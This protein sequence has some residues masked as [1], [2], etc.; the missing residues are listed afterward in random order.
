M[1]KQ[2][3]YGVW[4]K[5]PRASGVPHTALAFSFGQY[6][7]IRNYAAYLKKLTQTYPAFQKAFTSY[8]DQACAKTMRL[9]REYAPT[10]E[11]RPHR[12]NRPGNLKRSAYYIGPETTYFDMN[13]ERQE[14]GAYAKAKAAASRVMNSSSFSMVVGFSA[15]Y[16]LAVHELH[17]DSPQFLKR[18]IQYNFSHIPKD[19][20]RILIDRWK[21]LRNAPRAATIRGYGRYQ[22]IVE[23]TV[24]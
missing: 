19:M 5:F 8:M 12:K 7:S 15:S 20:E 13:V 16:A 22:S 4:R 1:M 6:V 17:P 9:A 11:G 23:S 24:G 14:A 3:R 2:P 18:A 21:G 10:S